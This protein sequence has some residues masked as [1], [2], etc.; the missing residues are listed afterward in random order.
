MAT[1]LDTFKSY[2]LRKLGRAGDLV[3]FEDLD[4]IIEDAEAELSRRLLLEDLTKTTP[5]VVDTT[6]KLAPLPDD[7]T[8]LRSVQWDSSLWGRVSSRELSQIPVGHV[9]TVSSTSTLVCQYTVIGRT[10]QFYGQVGDDFAVNLIYYSDIP[11]LHL[12][13]NWFVKQH[14]DVMTIAVSK[15]AAIHVQDDDMAAM[16]TALLDSVID[17]Q[18]EREADKAFSG[19]PMAQPALQYNQ[20]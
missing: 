17:Q 5:L 3:L 11:S 12:G 18:K 16:F 7:Y 8:L 10:I 2:V 9:N 1:A 15:H 19:A 6:T 20:A 4:E 14:R 13:N